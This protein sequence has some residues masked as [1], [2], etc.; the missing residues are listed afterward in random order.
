MFKDVGIIDNNPDFL[1]M[2]SFDNDNNCQKASDAVFEVIEEVYPDADFKNDLYG[3]ILKL[4]NLY[5]EFG[6]NLGC[7]FIENHFTKEFSQN[8]CDTDKLDIK[9][10]IILNV[11]IENIFYRM[12]DIIIGTELDDLLSDLENKILIVKRELIME[13]VLQEEAVNFI[14]NSNELSKL[15]FF[16]LKTCFK[17]G[18]FICFAYKILHMHLSEEVG[19]S[20]PGD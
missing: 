3:F 20:L 17:W 5:I 4:K 19:N 11:Y 16:L 7:F 13:S 6:V 9:N 2:S 8:F 12:L 14:L 18:V 15:R 1:K 10:I